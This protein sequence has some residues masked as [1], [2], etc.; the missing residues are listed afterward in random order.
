MPIDLRSDTVTLPSPK[1]R[2]AIARAELGDDVYGE[3]PTI[4]RLQDLAAELTGKE[5][6]IFVPSGTMG[7]LIAILTH[8]GRGQAVMVGD[9]SHIYHYE[10]GGASVLGGSPMCIIPNTKD[11][12]LDLEQVRT[13][14]ADESDAHVAPTAL[15]CIENTHNRCGGAVL[16]KEQVEAI[17]ELAH[18]QSIR[19]HMDGARV[20]NA[21]TALNIP[22]SELVKSVDSLM[23]CLSKGLSA[24]V[25]SMLVGDKEFIRQAHRTRKLLGGGMRQ[26]GVLAAAGIVALEEMVD[27]LAEDHENSKLLAQGLADFPQIEIDPEHVVTNI[28]Y[29]TLRDEQQKELTAGQT[30]LF[31]ARAREQGVLLG[32]TGGGTIRAVTHYGVE[33]QH[34][35]MALTGIRRALIDMHI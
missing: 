22:V 7:N 28:L 3:D 4:N 11:G 30:I 6:A 1:M 32:H 2:E 34:I 26:A 14:I 31:V 18:T 12:M 16:S 20:F 5:A 10:A 21:A 13:N 27:R 24:P 29:F 35:A 25:G 17:S 15:I 23:F 19:I 33:R 9:Q 8:V